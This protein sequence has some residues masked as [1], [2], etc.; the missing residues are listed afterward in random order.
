MVL[1]ITEQSYPCPKLNI[2]EV[3]QDLPLKVTLILSK[4]FTQNYDGNRFDVEHFYTK[5]K[6][7]TFHFGKF[8]HVHVIT[9]SGADYLISQ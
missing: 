4:N 6:N 3:M 2:C 7:L 5:L 1:E 9:F 8:L